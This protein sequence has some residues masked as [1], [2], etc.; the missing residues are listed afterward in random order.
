[1]SNTIIKNSFTEKYNAVF[2][3]PCYSTDN[4]AEL[5]ILHTGS[6]KMYTPD[7]TAPRVLT[8]SQLNFYIKSLIEN[9]SKLNIVFCP[10]KFQ[11][12]LTTT[13]R[14]YLSFTKR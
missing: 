1:M 6:L 14:T 4:A 8:V 9:D 3:E 5:H 12:S 2:A 13:E 11:I 7:F 10:A